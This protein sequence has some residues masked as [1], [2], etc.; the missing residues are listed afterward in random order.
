MFLLE[1]LAESVPAVATDLPG[2]REAAGDAAL[3]APPGNAAEMAEAITRLLRDDKL[4]WKMSKAA[5]KR[6][7]LF[8]EDRWLD[9]LVAMYQRAARG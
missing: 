7:A 2:C 1:A 6:V 8:D 9:G 5:T 3:Y 4:R